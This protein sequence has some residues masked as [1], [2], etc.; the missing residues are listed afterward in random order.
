MQFPRK[1]YP[2][3]WRLLTETPVL[4]WDKG[5]EKKTGDYYKFNAAPIIT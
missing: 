5:T 4:Y 3:E 2:R 1:N